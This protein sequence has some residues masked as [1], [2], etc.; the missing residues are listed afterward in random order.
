[1]REM[2][3]DIRGRSNSVCLALASISDGKAIVLA[4]VTP[5]LTERY[6]AGNL[7]KQVSVVFEGRGGGKADLAQAG[8][9]TPEKINAALD[10][11]REL[12]A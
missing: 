6:H 12:L 3:D 11:F 4:A 7:V 8:G 1:M 9:G 5:D 2:A 10:K